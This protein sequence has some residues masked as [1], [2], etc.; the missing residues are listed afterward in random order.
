MKIILKTLKEYWKFEGFRPLQEEIIKHYA[1]GK[2]TVILLP[3]G[4]GKSLCYQLPALL[5][6]G[7]TLVIS[8]LISLMQDQVNQMNTIGVKSMFFQSNSQKFSINQQMDNARFG[9]FKL[10]YCSPERLL[11]ADFIS[12]LKLLPLNGIAVDEAHCISEWG[13]D[14]RPAFKSIKDLKE[15]FPNLSMIALTATATPIV[16]EDIKKEL[17]LIKPKVF[18]TSFER[19]NLCYETLQ[20]ED[21]V[22]TLIKYFKNN[23]NPAIIY[24][25]SR[26]RTEEVTQQLKNAGLK[27]DFFHG[28]LS[29]D[30]KKEKLDNWISEKNL[31]IVATSAFGMGIDKS[32][33]GTVV[34]LL[35]PESME[36]YYQETGRAGRDGAT[37]RALLL[38]HPS[39]YNRLKDQFLSHLPDTVFIK[40]CFSNLCS[41]L[42]IPYGEG[43]GLKYQ[44]NLKE[45]SSRYKL[46]T[47]KSFETFKIL[48]REGVLKLVQVYQNKT[49]VQIICDQN[50]ALDTINQ[51]GKTAVVVQYLMRTYE[52]IF[53]HEQWVKLDE[54]SN[55]IGFSQ[56]EIL[57]I[58]NNLFQNKN[59]DLQIQN[60]DLELFWNVPR[61]DQYTLNPFLN[62]IKEYN[63]I[64]VQKVQ[65]MI[66]FASE[67]ERCKRNIIL[68]YFGE[69]KHTECKQCSSDSCRSEKPDPKELFQL[70]IKLLKTAPKSAYEIGVSLPAKNEFIVLA[71]QQLQKNK[72]IGQNEANQFYLN[73]E[74]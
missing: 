70:I 44:L 7:M 35:L 5:K 54:I 58:F 16:L 41:Y 66:D 14:F 3:T 37:A 64:K 51:G 9:K 36:A 40:K 13:H 45:F 19:K 32:N 8:P 15:L 31:I 53:N 18:T 12:Q 63:R 46:N 30:I 61:E 49:K 50:Q 28:G 68:N 29:T 62:N 23:Q 71:L 10:I 38:I 24:C 57:K 52:D 6:E 17:N 39:D 27:C 22:G 72:T 69:K 25:R 33:V 11:N 43:K 21:K 67:T 34:H 20:T 2:D 1:S 59:I 73:D 74:K 26:V 55:K 65:T 48:A 47:R 56:S 42:Q 4:G 60:T